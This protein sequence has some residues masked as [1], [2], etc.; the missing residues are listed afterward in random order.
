MR[1]RQ[2]SALA[3]DLTRL[4]GRTVASFYS[5]LVTRPTGRAVRL[6]VEQ[7]LAELS[8][9]QGPCL[10]I[11]DFS[12]VR[13]MDYSCAD[14]IVAKL[15]LGY[16]DRKGPSEVYFLARGLQDH[17]LESVEAVLER[18]GLLLAAEDAG[19]RS[20]L[21]G[22]AT[23]DE[24]YCWEV[25]IRHGRIARPELVPKS[26]LA[27]D[28]ILPTLHRFLASRVVVS[29]PDDVICPVTKLNGG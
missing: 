19:G 8:A 18:H 15:L 7:Q 3:I 6:G 24:R 28:V 16:S 17:H 9:D 4:N 27:E 2:T 1:A 14:E 21:L 25:L 26:G 5:D 22:P 12:Q 11:L 20:G 23:S 29:L 13:V 10:S